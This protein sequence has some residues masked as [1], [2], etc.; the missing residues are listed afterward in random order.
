MDRI[1]KSQFQSVVDN[2]GIDKDASYYSFDRAGVHFIVLDANFR[3][4]GIAYDTGNF[5]WTD[6]NIPRHQLEWLE[7]DLSHT[8]LPVIICMHQLIDQ[9][10]GNHYVRNAAEVRRLLER[11]PGVLAVF[12][13]HQHRGQYNWVNNIHYYTLKAMVEGTGKENNSYAIIE[14]YDDLTLS[15][16]GY[17][18]SISRQLERR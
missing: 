4:D 3:R 6:A 8:D 5:H 2:T 10:E 9:D 18:K 15:I 16:T 13:G 1:S 11:H 17:R 14:V 12:Q 7:K